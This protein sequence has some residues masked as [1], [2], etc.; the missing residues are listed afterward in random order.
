MFCLYSLNISS[1]QIIPKAVDA[2]EKDTNENN[3]DT[4][5]STNEGQNS[6]KY[7]SPL[8]T[9]Y[10]VKPI[11]PIK[12]SDA[13]KN[14]QNNS[15]EVKEILSEKSNIVVEEIL[16]EKSDIVVEEIVSEK[17]DF[18]IE[19][20]FPQKS[21]SIKKEESSIPKSPLLIKQIDDSFR[22]AKI[23]NDVNS[24]PIPGSIAEREHLKWLKAI[25]IENNPYSPEALH[26]RLSRSQDKH[27]DI[28]TEK[29]VDN[30]ESNNF[31]DVQLRE[32]ITK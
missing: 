13:L 21:E 2:N 30:D 5:F 16:P 26:K 10:L 6:Q 9:Q 32:D 29:V 8:L 24:P 3:C 15:D 27:I 25:P 20:N 11:Q 28:N 1:S 19:V 12:I 22:K 7:K 4:G 23:E 17:S 18:T 31:D 14:A